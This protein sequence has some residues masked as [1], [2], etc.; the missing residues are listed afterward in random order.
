MSSD[1]S[2]V[3]LIGV[4]D[5]GAVVDR[6]LRAVQNKTENVRISVVPAHTSGLHDP[7]GRNPDWAILKHDGTAL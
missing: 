3:G 7:A 2:G 6:A 4:R 1:A 5:E